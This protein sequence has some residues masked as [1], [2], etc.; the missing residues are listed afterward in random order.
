MKKPHPG[1]SILYEKM[2]RS[3]AIAEG[4][5]DALCQLKTCIMTHKCALNC[6]QKPCIKIRCKSHV[7]HMSIVT[8][9]LSSENCSLVVRYSCKSGDEQQLTTVSHTRRLLTSADCVHI[10][11]N[12]QSCLLTSTVVCCYKRLPVPHHNYHHRPQTCRVGQQK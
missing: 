6:T 4:P 12:H 11:C 3:S 1:H 9:A 10:S 5:R 2:K 7:H 8:M